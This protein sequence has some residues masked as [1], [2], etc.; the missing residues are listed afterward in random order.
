MFPAPRDGNLK[1]DGS[2]KVDFFDDSEVTTD[3]GS[4]EDMSGIKDWFDWVKDATEDMGDIVDFLPSASLPNG[5][6][7]IR[8]FAM[9]SKQRIHKLET[10]SRE[11][12]GLIQFYKEILEPISQTGK[13]KDIKNL[14]TIEMEVFLRGSDIKTFSDD[15][16]QDMRDLVRIKKLNCDR[17][18]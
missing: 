13:V 18:G 7:Q 12:L 3:D 10:S 11:I 5:E 14:S 16:V 2:P 1:K 8:L 6:G 17:S 4:D 9:R 15:L